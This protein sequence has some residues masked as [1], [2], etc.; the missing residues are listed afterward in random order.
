MSYRIDYAPMRLPGT[1]PKKTRR[2]LLLTGGAF[3]LFLLGTCL[4]WPEGATALREL[5]LPEPATVHLLS[6][7][8]EGV[9]PG[10][11]FTAFCQE[12]VANAQ[13]P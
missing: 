6:A 4:F 10:E 11:A 1:R 5:I 3:G 7:L 2:L 13:L 12:V 8:S 9:S